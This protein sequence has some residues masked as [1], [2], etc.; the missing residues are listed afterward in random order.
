MSLCLNKG[1]GNC[2]A[3]VNPPWAEPSGQLATGAAIGLH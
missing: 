1:Q 3:F 2:F